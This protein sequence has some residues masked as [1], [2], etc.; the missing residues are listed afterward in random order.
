MFLRSKLLSERIQEIAAK[1]AAISEGVLL[2]EEFIALPHY[3]S[4][5]L[6]FD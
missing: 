1:A 4:V 5:I 6:R 2:F 3:G